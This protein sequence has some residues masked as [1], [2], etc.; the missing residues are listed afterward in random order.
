MGACV[1]TWLPLVLGFVVLLVVV[2]S[3]QAPTGQGDL[4]VKAGQDR[5]QRPGRL[6]LV[7]IDSLRV[8]AMAEADTVPYLR[9]LAARPEAHW[10][11]VYTCKGNFTLPCVQ[12]LLEGKESP[13]ASGL[14]NYTG[15]EGAVASLP[16]LLH[17]LGQGVAVVGDH[18]VSSLYKPFA[19]ATINTDKWPAGYLARD[20]R[21]IDEGAR[22]LADPTV[23]LLVVHTAGTDKTSHH[24]KPGTA[25]YVEHFAKVS[26]RLSKLV[27]ALDLTRDALVITGDHGH[28][29][30]GHHNRNSLAVF[31]GRPLHQLF[32]AWKRAP[33]RIE[34]RDL[35]YFMAYVLHLPLPPTSYEGA[36]FLADAPGAPARVRAFEKLQHELLTRLGHAGAGIPQQVAHARA[37]KRAQERGELLS[38]LPLLVCYLGLLLWWPWLGSGRARWLAAAA[39]C[40][41]ALGLS[42][43]PP[44]P[45]QAWLALPL[46]LVALAPL[47]RARSRRRTLAL[48][49]LVAVASAASYVAADWAAFFHIR[50][51]FSWTYPAM[52]AGVP[53]AGL[54]WAW[55]DRDAPRHVVAGTAA[56]CL[57]ALPSGVY[58]YQAGANMMRGVA[59]ALALLALFWV[60]RKPRALL[61]R[62]Q[63]L[64]LRRLAPPLA[65]L[66]L[67]GPFLFLQEAG[68][69][70][71]GTYLQ[72][73]LEHLPVWGML[74]LHYG[75][76][77]LVAANL[78]GRG[79]GPRLVILALWAAAHL[80][81]VP[82][83]QLLPEQFVACYPPALLYI[84]WLELRLRTGAGIGAAADNE[85]LDSDEALMLV[86]AMA[87]T[88]WFIFKGY[89]INRV[90]F[91][92]AYD[93]LG[94][95][96]TERLF[97][98]GASAM[99]G[100]KYAI[101]SATLMI[102]T[103]LRLGRRHGF[104]MLAGVFFFIHVKLAVL[105]CQVLVGALGTGEKL[106][107]LGIAD[108]AFI[109]FML[110]K[111]CLVLIF[112]AAAVGLRWVV[113]T[114]SRRLLRSDAA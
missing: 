72:S 93:Y 75:V 11:P 81:A 104:V 33:Q 4:L 92:F 42:R 16:G 53:L 91:T 87:T 5:G 97:V 54:L 12:T 67:G 63:E 108:L 30:L 14:R 86:L 112:T 10:L 57:L 41:V 74:T 96:G 111:V 21:A 8:E 49:T 69:W 38:R 100:L 7:V 17:T 113:T 73:Y 77:L 45:W 26:Q 47:A 22:L 88:V 110:I 103:Y 32:T 71:W 52:L 79:W 3:S 51:G 40:G 106:Y 13:M 19:R 18:A 56:I 64:G 83:G 94:D 85:R 101:P 80:G 9:Q 46:A 109:G 44:A 23:R 27:A 20:L 31:L 34:Q 50:D 114:L 25:P 1:S 39:T 62:A 98:L 58:Y 2:T 48:V 90:D 65:L 76:G 95:V 107:Q 84:G 59:T 61:A 102:Y 60:V 55:L 6:V 78:T 105:L 66:A 24:H 99:V 35:L 43:L 36:Y 29:S 68:G 15:V 28:G 37:G 89:A 82:L 70:E